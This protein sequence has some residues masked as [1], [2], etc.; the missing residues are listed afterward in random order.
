[1]IIA[2]EDIGNAD[3]QALQVA[4]AAAQ[5]VER[6]GMPEAQLILAQAALYMATAPKSNSATVAIGEAM[7]AVRSMKATVPVHLQD[8]HY[9]GAHKLGHGVGYEYAHDYPKHFSGQRYL[10]QELGERRFYHPSDSGYERQVQEYLN[11]LREE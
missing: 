10:P 2:S 8:A 9:G 4:V 1:M 6:V 3:P 11:W 5:A 7:D